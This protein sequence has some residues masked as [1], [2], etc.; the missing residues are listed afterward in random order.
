MKTTMETQS[1]LA[2][3]NV[4]SFRFYGAGSREFGLTNKN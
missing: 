2:G 1:I 4:I 3:H